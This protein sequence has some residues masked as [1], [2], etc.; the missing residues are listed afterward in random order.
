VH[1][2]ELNFASHAPLRLKPAWKPQGD[3]LALVIEYSLNPAYSSAAEL[4]HNLVIIAHYTGARAT[5]CQTKPSGTHLKEKSLVYWRLGDVS[6]TNEWHKVICR[7]V[8]AEGAV[9][10]AGHIDAKW[11]LQGSASLSL[12]SG[13]S[14]SRLE[15]GKG[16]EKEES[17]DPFA[18][19]SVASPTTV[20]PAG[21]WVE[22]ETSKKLV[23]GTYEARQVEA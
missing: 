1:V 19:E 11:E 15:V 13:I 16:K 2:D 7:F 12:G 5:G 3:K 8:G 14:L 23:G 6:L 4:F 10:E 21:N 18:D 20:T 22:V 9:P 17:D